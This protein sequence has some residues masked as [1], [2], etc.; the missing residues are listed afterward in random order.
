MKKNLSPIWFLKTPL[1]PEHKEYVLLDYLKTISK[2][3]SH[4][5][6][7]AVIRR[8]SR[9]IKALNDYKSNRKIGN[10]TLK[11][12]KKEDKKIMDGFLSNELS[13]VDSAALDEIVQNSLN[14]LYEYSE[15]CLEML[16]EEETK[17][18]IFKIH[19]KFDPP[20]KKN[21][22]GI[23]IV[24][25]MVTDKILNY[26]FRSQVTMKTDDG[27]KEVFILK[28]VPT[29][30]TLFSLNYEYIYH[31]ILN[32]FSLNSGYFPHLYV[33]EINEN[34]EEESEIYKLAKERFIDAISN[35][36]T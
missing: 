29:K 30:N 19:S 13:K 27:D 25:N 5:N 24:R 28:K 33:I 15:I 4:E 36:S 2:D 21:D 10:S 3:L 23:L 7:F 32:G 17:I 34:F 22:S 1:D 16:K 14:T 26:F 9:I 12:L 8:I 11:L 18:K 6:C 35:E 31:E 20:I